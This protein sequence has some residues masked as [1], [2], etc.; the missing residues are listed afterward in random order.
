[1]RC[2]LRNN[3]EVSA[4]GNKRTHVT[5]H[6]IRAL[7]YKRYIKGLIVTCMICVNYEEAR[8]TQR[9]RHVV[10]KGLKVD[11]A[12]GFEGRTEIGRLE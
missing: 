9:I 3:K 7:T 10:G 2:H 6:R 11:R 12:V 5:Y 8:T 4:F 1:M